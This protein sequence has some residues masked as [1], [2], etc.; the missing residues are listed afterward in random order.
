MRDAGAFLEWA[1]V[2]DNHYGTPK[3][4]VEAAL[5]QGRDVLFDIDWQGAQQLYQL[6]SSDVVR[7]FIIPPSIAALEAR[8]RKRD[9]D[10]DAVIAGRMQRARAEISHWDNYDYVLVNDDLEACFTQIRHILAAERLKRAR[11]SGLVEFTR[12]LLS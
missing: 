1:Q 11:L 6:A 12:R 3:A 9:T 8:L 2:F 7:L 10:S 5:A 4:A